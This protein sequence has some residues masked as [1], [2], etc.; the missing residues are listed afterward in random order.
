MFYLLYGSA[1]IEQFVLC[2]GASTSVKLD[3]W[4]LLH[5]LSK[6]YKYLR[7]IQDRLARYTVAMKRLPADSAP[8]IMAIVPDFDVDRLSI[9][10][11][12]SR[13]ISSRP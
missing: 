11:L 13:S 9:R 12:K 8:R 5:D 10:L 3:E 2:H 7:K 4:E 1:Q 6:V